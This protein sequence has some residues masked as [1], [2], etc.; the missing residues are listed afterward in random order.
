MSKSIFKPAQSILCVKKL[1]Y[2]VS[3]W[4][5]SYPFKPTMFCIIRF[6]TGVFPIL[7]LVR[8]SSKTLSEIYAYKNHVIVVFNRKMYSCLALTI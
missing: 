8:I 5:T 6:R 7:S 4:H 2:N 3:L 1:E